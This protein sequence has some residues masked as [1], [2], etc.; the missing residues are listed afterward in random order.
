[1]YHCLPLI[2]QYEEYANLRVLTRL[3]IY[4]DK[5]VLFAADIGKTWLWKL[6]A[7]IESI[8]EM[9]FAISDQR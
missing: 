7:N 2:L 4:D 9:I 3:P 1:M 5:I 8:R 6:L